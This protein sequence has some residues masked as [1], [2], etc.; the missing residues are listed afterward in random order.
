MDFLVAAK[1]TGAL[2][3]AALLRHQVHSLLARYISVPSHTQH[4]H[5]ERTKAVARVHSSFF[6]HLFIR[7]FC[8]LAQVNC[9]ITHSYSRTHTRAQS[10]K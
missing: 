7:L 2:V 10:D 8:V 3:Y 1:T 9:E 6:P 4:T 5:S